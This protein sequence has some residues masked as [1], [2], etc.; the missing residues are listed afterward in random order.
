MNKM[1]KL[2][3]SMFTLLLNLMLDSQDYLSQRSFFKEFVLDY[4]LLT[5][6]RL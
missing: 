3:L 4:T 1:M 6:I 5:K 2:A